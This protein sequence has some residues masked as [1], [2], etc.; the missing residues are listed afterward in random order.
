M[1]NRPDQIHAAVVKRYGGL[2]RAVRDGW[3]VVDCDP[4]VFADGFFG[5][6]AYDDTATL[7]DGAVRA[8][9]GC[10]NPVAVADLRPGENVL[11]LGSGG[12][13][14]VLLSA[15]RVGPAGRAYGVDATPEMVDLA[16]ANAA[17][18]GVSNVDFLLGRIEDLPLPDE[19]VD[20]VISNCV[21]NLSPVKARVLAEAF[22][23][24]RPGGRLGLSDVIAREGLGAEQ[25]AA[26]EQRMGCVGTLTA[27]QY[28]DLLA[29]AGFTGIRITPTVDAG[30]ELT[31]AIVQ[32]TKPRAGSAGRSGT[33]GDVALAR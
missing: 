20:V 24:L 13:I 19:H 10:G 32:A 12:G 5:S 6:V 31:S 23:V 1:S 22:R 30:V 16:R 11:D 27:S 4:Q 18:A 7:P 33:D 21:V 28:H 29:S 25:R 17:E 9:L 14:D 3:F 2:A 8:S 26:A 15:R